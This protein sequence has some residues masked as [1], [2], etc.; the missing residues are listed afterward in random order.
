LG[1]SYKMQFRILGHACLEIE[2]G[3]KRMLVD[4]W[5]FGSAYW[6]SWW[7]YPPAVA[8]G[9]DSLSPD[10]IYISH[11]HFDHFHYPSMRKLGKD[12]VV[13]IPK[14]GIDLMPREVRRLGFSRVL[15]LPHGDVVELAPGLKIAS[16][17]FG[18]DDSA[19]V[20]A[21]VEATLANLNDCKISGRSAHQISAKF[22][23]P[24]FV[25]KSH[26]W[27]SAFPNCYEFETPSDVQ[28]LDPASYIA[29][30]VEAVQ[31]LQPD[32]AV[33]FASMVAFL[34]PDSAKCNQYMI[35]SK[36]VA[37]S[38]PAERIPGTQ[39]VIMNPG[40]SWSRRDGFHLSATDPYADLPGRL[41]TLTVAVQTQVARASAGE[42]TVHA[43]FDEFQKYFSDF[44]RALPVGTARMLRS[45]IVFEVLSAP[46][47]YWVLDFKARRVFRQLTLPNGWGSII[48]I[49]DAL[50]AD[51]VRKHIVHFVFISMRMSV[52]V[53]RGG[54]GNEVM[55][56][57]F[58]ILFELGY[59]PVRR[60]LNARMLGVFWRRRAEALQLALRLAS[61]GS[62]SER[63]LD[64]LAKREHSPS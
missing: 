22:G 11:H 35:T 17:Q 50:L 60:C 62:T 15:E 27:A 31:E 28:V 45:P 24:T 9:G 51:A 61:R 53:A 4:P 7:H 59:L 36:Q 8:M 34:H 41:E 39:L 14:F 33:P 49:P 18:F 64:H 1:Y 55:F 32:Y 52:R 47:P 13:I 30:F 19:L 10:F 2:S 37:E 63:L 29:S 56:W 40:D 54:V 23:K 26:S 44:V 3:Q 5:L 38:V 6:R 21:D 46:A 16:F 58:L 25:F 12:A 48:R 43:N 57:G 42:A 20:V